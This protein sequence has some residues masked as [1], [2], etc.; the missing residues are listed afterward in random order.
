MDMLVCGCVYAWLFPCAGVHVLHM[1]EMDLLKIGLTWGLL[2]CRSSGRT[3]NPGDGDQCISTENSWILLIFVDLFEKLYFK[4][5]A[6]Y[7]SIH[8]HS[9][10]V[11]LADAEAPQTQL[12]L[13]HLSITGMRLKKESW[14][15]KQAVGCHFFIIEEVSPWITSA[16]PHVKITVLHINLPVRFWIWITHLLKVLL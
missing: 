4:L 7:Y 1:H 14:G 8:D 11:V 12:W 9:S 3:N 10:F 5:S 13:H 6:K 16:G 2:T 15:Y